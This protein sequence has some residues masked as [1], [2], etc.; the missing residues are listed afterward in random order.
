MSAPLQSF[1]FKPDPS[2]LSR[3]MEN[4]LTL[5][6]APMPHL[7]SFSLG[8][9]IGSGARHEREARH[10]VSHFLEHMAFKGTKRRSAL[11]IAR[12]IENVGGV[13]NAATGYETTQYWA[14][15]PEGHLKLALDILSDI[16]REPV[17]DEEEIARE[18]QVVLQ[19]IARSHDDPEEIVMDL[20][21]EAAYPKNPLGRSILGTPSSVQKLTRRHLRDH[22]A[23]HYQ[24]GAMIVAATGKVSSDEFFRLAESACSFQK[25]KPPQAAPPKS[26][27]IFRSHQKDSAQTH[28]AAAWRALPQGDEEIPAQAVFAHILG[29]GMSSRLFQEIR[30]KRGLCYAVS[31]FAESFTDTGLLGFHMATAP[32]EAEA[33]LSEAARV[34]GEMARGVEEEELARA[35]AGLHAGLVMTLESAT[36]RNGQIAALHRIYQTVPSLEE[37]SRRLH[38]VQIGDLRRF[39]ERLLREKPALAVVGPAIPPALPDRFAA[40]L[41]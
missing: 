10:G 29:D 30:E 18:R 4:G 31:S 24:A 6:C 27:P 11:D 5:L 2:V 17:F 40:R 34:I 1:H 23:D 32:K 37:R 21:M 33:A 16:L 19:E 15:C 9:W 35:K 41:A 7:K 28:V 14:H 12:A 25:G 39:A 38:K 13:I 22:I 20:L 8:L 26:A 3:R 36:A